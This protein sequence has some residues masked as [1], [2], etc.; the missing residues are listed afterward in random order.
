MANFPGS[1]PNIPTSTSSQFLSAAGGIGHTALHNL[2]NGEVLALATKIGTG[3]S[4]PSNNTFLRGTGS[5]TSAWSQVAL[6]TDVTGVLPVANGGTGQDSLTGLTLPSS[7]L[8]NPTI[9]GTVA[10]GATYTSPVLTIPTIADFSNATH[11]HASNAQGGQLNGANSI[12]DGTITPA[13]L[14]AGTGS[15][16]TPQSFTPTIIA[17]TTNPTYGTSPTQVGYYLQIGKFVF[18]SFELVFGTGVPTAGTGNYYLQ[19]PVPAITSSFTN[20]RTSMAGSVRFFDSSA[21]LSVVGGLE[22]EPNSIH[23][24]TAGTVAQLIYHDTNT[25][26]AVSAT[27]PLLLAAVTAAAPWAWDVSDG[28][29]GSFWYIAA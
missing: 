27:D 14:M 6:T 28:I 25:S 3:S 20:G 9:S 13:E 19:L 8:A 29:A 17:T 4:I 21:S 1:L 10:G 16:W 7:I 22:Y 5:G 18:I 24:E 23:G 2:I 12:I 11:T 15:S 26:D